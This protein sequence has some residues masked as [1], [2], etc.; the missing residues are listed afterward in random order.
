MVCGVFVWCV[1]VAC[2]IDDNTQNNDHEEDDDDD[3]DEMCVQVYMHA[4][5]LCKCRRCCKLNCHREK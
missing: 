5:V 4:Y 1:C 2:V 3:D